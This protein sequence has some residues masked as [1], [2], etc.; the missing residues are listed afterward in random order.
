MSRPA[1]L[2][3]SSVLAARIFYCLRRAEFKADVARALAERSARGHPVA[4]IM[5]HANGSRPLPVA[6]A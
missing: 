4:R 2:E 5:A 3:F 6:R 1:P